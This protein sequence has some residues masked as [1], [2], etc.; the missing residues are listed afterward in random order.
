MQNIIM[1]FRNLFFTCAVEKKIMFLL[2]IHNKQAR[3]QDFYQRSE[4]FENER[5]EHNW[6]KGM[7]ALYMEIFEVFGV[8]GGLK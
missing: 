3:I 5:S 7:G 1:M 4:N 8:Y 2:F 6:S